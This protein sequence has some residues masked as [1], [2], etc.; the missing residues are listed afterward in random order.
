MDCSRPDHWYRF[1]RALCHCNRLDEARIA[2]KRCLKMERN[3]ADALLVLGRIY[4]L[5]GRAVQARKQVEQVLA[6]KGCGER[7]I[8][9][10]NAL[11]ARLDAVDAGSR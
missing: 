11:L 7:T 6:L 5:Q 1:G 10:A 4:L 8:A 9:E 2:V 3:H